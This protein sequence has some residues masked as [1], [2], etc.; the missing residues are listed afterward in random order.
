MTITNGY[1][2]TKEAEAYIGRQFADGSGVLDDIITAASRMVD[3]HCSRHFYTVTATRYF[4]AHGCSTL[5]L[6]AFNDLVSVTTMKSDD[7]D[8]GTYETTHTAY[9]LLPKGAAGWAP[10]GQPYTSLRLLNS[11]TFPSC[12]SSGREGLIEIAG[13]WGWP[14]VA[15]DVK[16]A[17]RVIVA[18]LAKL[19]DAPLGMLGSAEFGMSRIPPQKQ[20]HVRDLLAPFVHPLSWGI[21]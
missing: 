2:T 17:T 21:A 15:V 12:P 20:R 9:Q 8:D 5:T 16:Q 7:N 10:D 14:A 3:R 11:V 18:E 6:G 19:Q 1:L 4:D 13:S